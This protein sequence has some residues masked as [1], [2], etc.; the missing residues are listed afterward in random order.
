VILLDTHAWVWWVAD[1]A[2]L[3][4]V[5]KARLDKEDQ[6]AISD[7]SLWEVATLVAKG[8]LLLDRDP[9]DWLIQASSGVEII[10]IRPPIAVRSTQLGRSFH[11]DPADR[12]IV[13]TAI[14]ENASLVTRDEKIRAF[15]GVTSIW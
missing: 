6:L 14:L 8:R 3:S 12:L 9:T 5:A 1:K 15:P 7:I 13:A 4:R 11:G 2:R 10:P